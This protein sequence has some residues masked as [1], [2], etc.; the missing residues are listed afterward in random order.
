MRA[1][2]RVCVCVCVC[3][4]ARCEKHRRSSASWFRLCPVSN[5][6][7]CHN[8]GMCVV[9]ATGRRCVCERPFR[10]RFC[11]HS[12]SSS[13]AA[14]AAAAGSSSVRY[15]HYHHAGVGAGSVCI[16][17]PCRNGGICHQ[18]R[19]QLAAVSSQHADSLLHPHL[20]PRPP[21]HTE[22]LAHSTDFYI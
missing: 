20:Y 14:A 17:N 1:C 15:H 3:V 6:L 21:T 19:H 13:S 5:S 4:G 7:H 16:P 18:L 8:G 11:Q 10:G 2:V 9:T 22:L 12:L